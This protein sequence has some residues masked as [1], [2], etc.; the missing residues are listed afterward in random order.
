[1]K[2]TFK[3][4]LAEAIGRKYSYDT[5]SEFIDFFDEDFTVDKPGSRFVIVSPKKDRKNGIFK[6]KS[7]AQIV[8]IC[9]K[10]FDD[11]VTIQNWT[12]PGKKSIEIF[13]DWNWDTPAQ[14][15][16]VYTVDDLYGL[17]DKDRQ[18]IY[19]ELHDMDRELGKSG[20]SVGYLLKDFGTFGNLVGKFVE[21]PVKGRPF[22]ALN[23]YSGK[24]LKKGDKFYATA[25][26][27]YGRCRYQGTSR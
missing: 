22:V 10:Y 4:F 18:R 14:A 1:M 8:A 23:S 17:S 27:E 6:D 13:F 25:D 19:S 21:G 11:T 26:T 5:I 2:T 7:A 15:E 12:R 9:Q 24:D 3:S 16:V 20:G